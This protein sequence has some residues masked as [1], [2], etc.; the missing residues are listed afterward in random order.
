MRPLTEDEEEYLRSVYFDPDKSASYQ[1]P[2]RLYNF[3]KNDGEFSITLMQIK[4]WLQRQEAYSLNR[5]V[6]RNF[7]RS[8]VIVAGLDDQWEADL[9]D[10]QEYAEDNDGYKY[11]LFVMDVFSRYAWVQPLKSKKAPEIVQAFKNIL[12]ENGERYPD[13]LR[14]DA[15][16]D[17]TSS[18]FQNFMKSENIHHFVTHSEKQANYVERLIQTIKRK[19][20]RHIVHHNNPRYIDDLQSLVTSYNQTFH[21]GIQ[22]EPEKVNKKNQ[23]KLWWQMYWPK[24]PPKG[25]RRK[26]KKVKFLFEIGDEV[27]IS[28]IR[29]AFQ[30]EYSVR[31]SR[32]VFKVSDRFIRQ[33]Q[34]IYKLVDWDG[35][36]VEGTFYQ[37]ELQK[38]KQGATF[39]IQKIEQYKGRGRNRQALVSWKGWP[40]K[41]NSWILVSELQR[42]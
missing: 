15:A 10:L 40:K 8:R 23:R 38:T 27:R 21:S 18:T 28:F 39:K 29:S 17:F 26:K 24:T 3:V 13:R 2:L 37:K 20:F 22:S 36:R 33:N 35:D 9:A 11:L 34:P 19:L 42:I 6:L 30:R 12:E 7:Q 25:Q 31:W 1:S 5:N 14:T 4:D 16:T 32:E 41:F